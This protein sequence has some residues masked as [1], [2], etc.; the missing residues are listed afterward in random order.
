ME[1]CESICYLAKRPSHRCNKPA[2]F[3]WQYPDGDIQYLCGRHAKNLKGNPEMREYK[4][5]RKIHGT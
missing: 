2:K 4:I 5:V 3:V 1:T